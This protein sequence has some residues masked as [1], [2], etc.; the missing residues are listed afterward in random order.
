VNSNYARA[1]AVPAPAAAITLTTDKLVGLA[2]SR[3]RIRS[4]T[5]TLGVC[6]P[7]RRDIVAPDPV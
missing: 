7:D 6:R 1:V 3:G 5:F 4:A 2:L